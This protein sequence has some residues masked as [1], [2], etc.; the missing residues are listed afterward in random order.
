MLLVTQ[1][2]IIQSA[3]IIYN[4][5]SFLF[6]RIVH[7]VKMVLGFAALSVAFGGYVYCTNSQWQARQFKR[8]HPLFSVIIILAAGY[9]LVY[10]FGAVIVF[11]FGIAFPLLCKY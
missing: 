7:P 1:V 2:P 5:L 9:L 3:R 6:S 11:M 10:M 4:L 8:N